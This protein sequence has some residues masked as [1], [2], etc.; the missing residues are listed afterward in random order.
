MSTPSFPLRTSAR[1]LAVA[2]AA[3]AV[4]I[5]VANAG[6]E[7]SRNIE[8]R[9]ASVTLPTGNTVEQWNKIAEDTVVGSGAFQIEGFIY[10]AYEST[11]VYDATVA[12]QGGYEPLMPAFRVWKGASPDA[13]IV[14][15]AYRTLSHYFPAAAATLHP[16]YA[17]ALAAIPSG[18]AKLAGQRIGRGA[19]RQVLRT[20]T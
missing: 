3:I 1:S 14:E 8:G 9:T 13:A 10:M 18:Q 4:V 12:L 6:L 15:A 2:L 20:P 7:R 5:P 16:L 17:A 11:A 19:P